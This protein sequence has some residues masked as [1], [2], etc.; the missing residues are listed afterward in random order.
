MPL[1]FPN[2]PATNA[3]YSSGGYTW[4][5]DGTRWKVAPST[6]PTY[7]TTLPSS[8]VDGQEIYYQASGDMTTQGIVWHLRYRSAARSNAGAWEFVGGPPLSAGPSG[9]ITTNTQTPT[10]L[11]NGPTVTLPRTG[12]FTIAFGAQVSSW[13]GFPLNM[14]L[15]LWVGSSNPGWTWVATNVSA[16]E[17]FNANQVLTTT[18]STGEVVKLRVENTNDNFGQTN[19]PVAYDKGWLTITPHFLNPA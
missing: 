11:T 2:N 3:T 19:Y 1:D 5:F 6:N 17:R 18:G 7:Q 10:D 4:R 9:A 13:G 16:Y 12:T 15:L 8:P 14:T